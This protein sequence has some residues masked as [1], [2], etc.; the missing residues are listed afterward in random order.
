MGVI[1][2]LELFVSDTNIGIIANFVWFVKKS[3]RNINYDVYMINIIRSFK[4]SSILQYI[5]TKYL[6]PTLIIHTCRYFTCLRDRS[7]LTTMAMHNFV[8]VVQM[9]ATPTHDKTKIANFVF[10]VKC[11]QQRW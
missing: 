9:G 10:V 1:L 4:H 2:A 6:L 7:H 3:N 5:F 8:I 11:Q